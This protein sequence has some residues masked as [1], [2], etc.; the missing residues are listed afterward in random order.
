MIAKRLNIPDKIFWRLLICGGIIIIIALAGIVPLAR[1]NAGLDNDIKKMQSQIEEQK[2]LKSLHDM[3]V[4]NM[5]KKNSLALPNPRRTAMPRQEANRF[6][7]A[8]RKIADISGLKTM[9]IVP[10][11]A[12]LTGSSN[13]LL[14]TAVVKGDFNN[15]RKMLINL[16]DL[17]YLE[18][19]EEINV[20]QAADAMEFR[21]RL[22]IALGN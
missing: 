13:Q 9:S 14:H 12:A 2:N 11:L 6:Q 1:Y 3:L 4:K 21:I 10:E 22:L 5:E 19:I 17:P 18:R 20:Q 16:G 7:D 15:F 8:F